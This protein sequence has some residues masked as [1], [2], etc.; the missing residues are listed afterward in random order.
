MEANCNVLVVTLFYSPLRSKLGADWTLFERCL[1][2]LN[3]WLTLQRVAEVTDRADKPSVALHLSLHWHQ[4]CVYSICEFLQYLPEL[5]SPWSGAQTVWGPRAFSA[6][7]GWVSVEPWPSGSSWSSPASASALENK[8]RS[9]PPW[10]SS[11]SRPLYSTVKVEQL[12]NSPKPE[13]VDKS[14]LPYVP[15]ETNNAWLNL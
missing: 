9:P 5:T 13:G 6:A 3:M 14:L 15:W 2:G 11:A 7:P 1:N 8:Q 12:Q 4:C 10:C